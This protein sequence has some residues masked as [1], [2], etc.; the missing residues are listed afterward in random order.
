MH[1]P[2]ILLVHGFGVGA[3]QWYL[4]MERLAEEHQVWALDLL[5][6]GLSWPSEQALA[7]E[8]CPPVLI[9]RLSTALVYFV[10]LPMPRVACMHTY[11]V[12]A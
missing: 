2:P 3:F 1:G 11:T 8:H 12:C 9:L 4:L 5:G 10:A 6:Q 7:G